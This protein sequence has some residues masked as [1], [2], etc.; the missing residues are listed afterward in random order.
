MKPAICAPFDYETP[1][2]RAIPMIRTAGFEV[3]SI[4][5]R[6]RHPDYTSA[7]GRKTIRKLVKSG[8]LDI[9]SVH[10]PFPEGDRLFSLDEAE[11]LES[12][13][14]C[15]AALDAAAELEGRTV[16]IHLIQPYGIP[17]GETRDRMVEA[18]RQ[19]VEALADHAGSRGVK[20]ALENGQRA[21]YDA[22]L[23]DFLL[24]F[25]ADHVGFCYDSGHEN[26][27]GTCF[28]ILEEFG[29]RLLTVHIHDNLGSDTHLLP[30]EGNIDWAKF[31]RVFFSLSYSG[32]L[33][34]ESGLANSRFQE[35]ERFLAEARE[36]AER[37]INGSGIPTADPHQE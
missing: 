34:L 1:L 30:Y 23:R 18:G 15:Q 9:E 13:R 32:H 21:D 24:E 28:K 36:R 11:R 19:S 6:P 22:V 3:I 26:V 27:Q 4:G 37:I 25:K 35:P 29:S 31:R 2:D 10:A 12:I 5:G 20:L 33:L 16:V 17:P 7:A 8:G 14:Q